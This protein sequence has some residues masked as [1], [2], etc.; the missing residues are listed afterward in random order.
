MSILNRF[1]RSQA[2][3]SPA[4][5][6][7][8]DG[9][10]VYAIGDVHGRL[11]L[12]DALLAQIAADDAARAPCRTQLLLLG[13]LVDRGPESAGVVERARELVAGGARL[14]M[15][16]HEEMFLRTVDGDVQALRVMLRVG[17]KETILSYGVS[18]EEFV[19][20]DF[21]ELLALFIARVPPE[22]IVFLRGSENWIRY[23]DYL[24][25]HAGIRPAVPL[26]EQSPADL[27]W[28][29]R[30]FLDCTD[31]HGYVVVHG[32]TIS[33][34]VE[35]RPNRI[36]IDTGAFASGRL[37]ALGLEGTARWYLE[38]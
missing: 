7:L 11:D 6:T 37:T 4:P 31:D 8:P 19:A 35:E 26:E 13:D 24:F 29:R 28:I 5:A 10:R 36:G 32:H 15:G 23:G 1:R 21:D 14:L 2:P 16:N 12:L 22:H 38:T 18:E 20:S 27:R 17:G 33:E 30:E 25:A 3:A 9:L 34:A